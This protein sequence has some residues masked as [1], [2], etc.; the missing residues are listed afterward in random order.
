[1]SDVQR[2]L[3]GN[4]EITLNLT[5][6]RGIKVTG[7][8]YS[9]DTPAD[10]NKRIDVYQD[11]LNRQAVAVDIISKEAQIESLQAGLENGAQHYQSLISEK[12]AKGKLNSQQR[13]Q[14]ERYDADVRG[15]QVQIT[16]LQAAIARARA[17]LAE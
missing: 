14:L 10:I 5:Q 9:D 4:M 6:S 12:A 8:I 17:K 13:A 15:V 7:Y 1:M 11:C 2:T 3:S 16:S